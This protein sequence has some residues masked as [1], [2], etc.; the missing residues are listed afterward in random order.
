MLVNSDKRHRN[1]IVIFLGLCVLFA[2]AIYMERDI[3]LKEYHQ[4]II[5]NLKEH[6][7][8]KLTDYSKI[9]A[10]SV[11]MVEMHIAPIFD[12]LINHDNAVNEILQ[13]EF[14]AL[15]KLLKNE[16]ISQIRLYTLE[17]SLLFD[18][19]HQ[20]QD[21]H[22][23]SST[24]NP[25]LQNALQTQK[26]SY[27]Y[28][29]DANFQGFRYI[30]PI[31]KD[32]SILGLA[33]ISIP[34]TEILNYL[35]ETTKIQT[36]LIYQKDILDRNQN[37]NETLPQNK[38][39]PISTNHDYLADNHDLETAYWNEILPYLEPYSLNELVMNK[40]KAFVYLKKNFEIELIV[41]TPIYNYT[42]EIIGIL[43]SVSPDS[44]CLSITLIQL[45]K[46]LLAL[47]IFYF[48]HKFYTKSLRNEI[49]LNQYKQAVDASALISKTDTSGKITYVNDSFEKLSGYSKKELLGKKHRIIRAPEVSSSIFREMWNTIQ[50]GG[51][52]QGKITNRKKNGE[53]YTVNSTILP[54]MDERGK[55]IEYIAIRYD[56][57]QLEA[58]REILEHRLNDA[59]Q[60]LQLNIALLQQYQ[61]AIEKAS[62]FCRFDSQGVITYVNKTMCSISHLNE[63]DLLHHSVTELGLINE[64]VFKTICKEVF[65][66]KTWNGVIECQHLSDIKCFLDATFSPIFENETLKEIMCISHDITPLYQLYQ[67]IEDTQKEVVFTMGA[68]GESR[69]QETGNHVKRVA[70]YSKL[71]AKLYGLST[72]ESELLKQASPMHDIGKVGIPD[73]ILN[74]PGK[75]NEEE[76]IVMKTHSTLGYEMLKH[77]SRPLLK[78]ASIVAH[79]H[80]EKWN[81]SGY[82]RGL[83]GNKIHIY[84]RITS[85][86]DVFD[87]LGSD[88]CYKKAWELDKILDLFKTERGNSFDPT[89][90]DL[91]LSNM[92]DF[93]QIKE[94]FKD[95]FEVI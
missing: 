81:G 22:L 80:H 62:S 76:W 86:A 34:F 82:P 49:L 73:A 61:N 7:D 88:R 1:S 75:L 30:A 16:G 58:Y 51:I 11:K 14:I 4:Q 12:R 66:G 9:S 54:I 95:S 13:H 50:K 90:V 74:K 68:I 32:N 48:L 60:D 52:W 91:L 84:G 59:D 35:E 25:I 67:E 83:E 65:E 93:L 89:L 26:I 78:A 42:H 92:D 39:M 57:S 45:F 87:A 5:H 94:Q 46:F 21:I 63:A 55:I 41:M 47:F 79:E 23:T 64:A 20:T 56:I 17:G 8:E 72:E 31:F 15:D 37:T 85:I 19:R 6:Y 43:I 44:Q 28:D 70:E 18:T 24:H 53:R 2:I 3:R 71:L 69:S 36:Y 40:G 10:L 27:G 38:F 33:E 29:F 77:S